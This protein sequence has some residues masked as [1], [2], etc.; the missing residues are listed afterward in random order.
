[1]IKLKCYYIDFSNFVMS[2]VAR[3]FRIR[4]NII[5]W[6]FQKNFRANLTHANSKRRALV[7]SNTLFGMFLKDS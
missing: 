6:I 7:Q 5:C 3:S 4:K 1:M 2:T